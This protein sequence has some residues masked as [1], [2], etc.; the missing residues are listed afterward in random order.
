MDAVILAAG[1]GTR[2]RPLTLKTPKPLLAVGGKSILTHTLDALPPEIDRIVIVVGY[3]SEQIVAAIGTNYNGRPVTY[4][5]QEKLGGTGAALVAAKVG[6]RPGTFLVL[7]GDDLYDARD[8]QEMVKHPY[9]ILVKEVSDPKRFGSIEL[10]TDGYVAAIREAGD[11]TP[12]PPYLV[13]CAVYTLDERYFA[14]PPRLTPKGEAGLPQTM[15]QLAH[16]PANQGGPQKIT[17]V[18][19]HEWY[20]VGTPEELEAVRA[21]PRFTR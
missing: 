15:A 6:L 16:L 21:L 11:G 2:L 1:L 18:R 5:H 10:N 13:N 8:L 4:V 7:M 17:A 14:L 20:S 3:L 12:K 9:A 19:A